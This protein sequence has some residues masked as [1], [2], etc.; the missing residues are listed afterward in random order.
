MTRDTELWL[1]E[2]EAIE[3]GFKDKEFFSACL[4]WPPW[5]MGR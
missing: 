4:Q 2:G 1:S 3:E 5:V